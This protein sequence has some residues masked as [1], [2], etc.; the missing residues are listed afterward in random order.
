MCE[1]MKAVMSNFVTLLV[2]DDSLQRELMANALAG[3]GLEV[4]ECTTAEAAE[5]IVASTGADL[6]ALV[7]DQNLAGEMTGTELAAFARERHPH[8]STSSPDQPSRRCRKMRSFCK[9]PSCRA[10]SLKRSD[11]TDGSRG[12]T[13]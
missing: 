1:R 5:A 11:R 2:E 6:L 12:S 10:S 4:V 9:S 13:S 8:L 3:E 7:T